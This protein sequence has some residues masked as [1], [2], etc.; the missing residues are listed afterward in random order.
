MNLTS[1]LA[2]ELVVESWLNTP[3][4]ITLAA[5]R[6][7]VVVIEAFQML[8]PGCVSH[9]LPLLSRVAETF[10]A[11]DVVTLGLHTVFEHHE[12]QGSRA[13]LEVFLHEYRIKFPVGI[14][15]PNP[16]GNIS[17]TM[18]AYRLQGT[19]SLLVID[20]QGYLRENAFGHVSD[21][22]VGALI[23]QL[24]AGVRM[25]APSTEPDG[26]GCTEEGCTIS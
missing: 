18:N 19:P 4:P 22:A 14:D 10:S 2:P 25:D 7:K 15:A 5:L 23:G 3:E 21:L 16:A 26:I 24:L 8:C 12:V 20:Q 17:T 6:G 13:A 9:G 11:D 1:T